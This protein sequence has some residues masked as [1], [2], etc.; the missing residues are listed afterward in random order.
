M[1]KSEVGKAIIRRRDPAE[2]FHTALGVLHS[3]LI[4][5]PAVA[6]ALAD[7]LKVPAASIEFRVDYEQRYALVESKPM[8]LKDLLV[9]ADDLGAIRVGLSTLGFASSKIRL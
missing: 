6:V 8:L 7:N 1:I 5:L 4:E 3:R 9:P 2:V